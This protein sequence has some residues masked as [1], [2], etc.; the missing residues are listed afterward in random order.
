MCNK[1][2]YC[3]ITASGAKKANKG[4][5]P[6]THPE[7]TKL[8]DH[9]HRMG[10]LARKV[11]NLVV[12]T[13]D[14]ERLKRNACYAVHEYKGYDFEMFKW[15]VW[16]VLYHH[17]SC[18]NKCGAWCPWLKNQDNPEELKKL[19]YCN[20]I[21]DVALHEHILEIWTTY[22]CS[23]KA[24]RGIH[25]EWHTNKCELMNKFTLKFI[26]K[27]MHLC[28][29]IIGQVRIYLAVALESVG[30]K[31]TTTIILSLVF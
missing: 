28:M 30:M 29:S 11:Y 8:A 12:S 16:A 15:M 20:K 18:H 13:A 25:H 4:K 31:S 21:K 10:C 7:W 17:F 6:H 14:A 26:L 2:L 23:D 24:L 22:Y 3:Q 27:T 1:N 9:H 19:F 5:L